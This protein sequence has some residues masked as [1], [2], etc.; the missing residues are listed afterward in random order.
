VKDYAKMKGGVAIAISGQKAAEVA[1][2]LARKEAW[3]LFDAGVATK[4]PADF[5]IPKP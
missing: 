5:N 1:E 4:S 3:I 2:R